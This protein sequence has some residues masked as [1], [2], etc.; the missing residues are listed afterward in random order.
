MEA[1]G[2]DLGK[3]LLMTKLLKDATDIVGFSLPC[4][5]LEASVQRLETIQVRLNLLKASKT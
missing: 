5:L 1:N 3:L 2:M 4:S